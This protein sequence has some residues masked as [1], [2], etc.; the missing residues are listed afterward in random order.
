MRAD[1][2]IRTL[3]STGPGRLHLFLS[4][5]ALLESGEDVRVIT[6]WVPKSSALQMVTLASRFGLMKN[7][8]SRLRTRARCDGFPKERVLCCP[9]ADGVNSVAHRLVAGDKPFASSVRRGSWD[10]FGRA[11]CRH[12]RHGDIFHVRSG[13]GGSGAI[14]TARKR[15]FAVVV[16]HSIAHPS[17]MATALNDEYASYGSSSPFARNDPFWHAVED[18]CSAADTVL[19]NSDF[20]AQTFA[21]Q[22]FPSDR[23]RV[24]YLGVAPE[25]FGLKHDYTVSK[26]P[27]QVLFVGEFGVRKGAGYLLDALNKLDPERQRFKLLV[28]GRTPEMSLLTRRHKVSPHDRFVGQLSGSDV[29]SIATRADVFVFPSLAEGCARAAMEAMAAGL[30]VIATKETGLPAEAGKHAM[31]VASRSVESLCEALSVISSDEQL[32]FDI[33]TAGAGFATDRFSWARYG[34]QVQAIH[35]GVLKA[36]GG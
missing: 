34:R 22:G 35:A 14:S 16:D 3:I 20:V 10:L 30:P 8:A 23:L 5:S 7:L 25:W 29:R 4:A 32:R 27:L 15:G 9:Y 31:I 24:S 17:W 1:A 21:Q 2:G 26:R 12:I 28:V 13:A 18:D 36:S 11:S 6:G 19:V 33:G